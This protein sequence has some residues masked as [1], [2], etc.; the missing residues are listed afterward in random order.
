MRAP[1]PAVQLHVEGESPHKYFSRGSR[2]VA[3]VADRI[4]FDRTLEDDF[5]IDIAIPDGAESMTLETDQVYMPADRS[6]PWRKSGDLRHL[7]LRI[8]KCELR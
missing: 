5:A 2:L 8:F 3:R 1:K 7:G 4:V 6:R